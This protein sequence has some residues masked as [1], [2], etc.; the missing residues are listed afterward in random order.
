MNFIRYE[1]KGYQ[2]IIKYKK[3]LQAVVYAECRTFMLI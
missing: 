2:P 1:G 3:V